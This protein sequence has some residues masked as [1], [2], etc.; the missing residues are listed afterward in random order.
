MSIE[1]DVV[2]YC[3][4]FNILCNEHWNRYLYCL[5]QNMNRNK[6]N[7]SKYDYFYQAKKY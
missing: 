6:E 7:V 2:V 1:R 5:L 4:V 3:A